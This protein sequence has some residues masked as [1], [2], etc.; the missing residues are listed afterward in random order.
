MPVKKRVI[1]AA[2][3]LIVMVLCLCLI[4]LLN[5]KQTFVHEIDTL[6]S[7]LEIV[8][9]ELK[10][11]QTELNRINALR[12]KDVVYNKKYPLFSKIVEVAYKKAIE[13]DFDPNLVLSL[14]Q[15]ESNFKP[16]AV[17]SKGAFGLMQINYSVWKNE[18]AI[19]FRKIFDIEY[20][21]DLGLQVLKHYYQKTGG[22]LLKTL[23]LYNNGY[24]HNNEKY[25]YKVI[26]TCFY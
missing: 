21:I 25:K 24:L 18:L 1:Y 17:S 3:P 20:N 7:R 12:Y 15:I 9:N 6:K 2:L 8:E 23:H 19:N 13:Y 4:K 11:S 5:Q 10:Q 16:F 26:S 22:D 14:I